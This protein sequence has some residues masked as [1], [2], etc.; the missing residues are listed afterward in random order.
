V[1]VPRAVVAIDEVLELG[2]VQ[3]AHYRIGAR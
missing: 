1:V 3:R 2:A